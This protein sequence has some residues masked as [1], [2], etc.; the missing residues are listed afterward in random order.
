M[1]RVFVQ[2]CFPCVFL[3]IGI[4]ILASCKSSPCQ[5]VVA[6]YFNWPNCVPTLDLGKM[7]AGLDRATNASYWTGHFNVGADRRSGGRDD[8]GGGWIHGPI[9]RVLKNS[10]LPGFQPS[11]SSPTRICLFHKN[12]LVGPR[13]H[14]FCCMANMSGWFFISTESL[15]W[16]SARLKPASSERKFLA[17]PFFKKTG[18]QSLD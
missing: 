13:A 7:L 10:L 16:Q 1:M 8:G 3:E 18:Q 11:H 17:I 6:H 15:R 12:L 2:E 4:E 14:E 9:I 5:L